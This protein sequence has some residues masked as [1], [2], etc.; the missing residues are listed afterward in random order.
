METRLR[1]TAHVQARVQGRD[2]V[3]PAVA[4][5]VLVVAA[6]V[7][8][9]QLDPRTLLLDAPPLVGHWDVRLSVRALL[10]VAVGVR[11]FVLPRRRKPEWL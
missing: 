2:T 1:E 3:W 10:P 7:W 9:S 6:G 8:G 4:A 11:R 5:V